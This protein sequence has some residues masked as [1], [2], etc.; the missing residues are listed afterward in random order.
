MNTN[1]NAFMRI[2]VVE[3]TA[4]PAVS[5]AC[6]MLVSYL[7][8]SSTLKSDA[9]CSSETS[10]Y[11]HLQLVVISQKIYVFTVTAVRALSRRF[12]VFKFTAK[13]KR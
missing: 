2:Y 6:S 3:A 5:V 11:Y 9:I 10:D 13:V 12:S 8:Y 1:N 4:G 7:A